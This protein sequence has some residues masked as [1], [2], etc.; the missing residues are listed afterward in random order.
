MRKKFRTYWRPVVCFLLGLFLGF[1]LWSGGA[2]DIVCGA[3]NATYR[4]EGLNLAMSDGQ[5]LFYPSPD[6]SGALWTYLDRVPVRGQLTDG[7]TGAAV[8]LVQVPGGRGA[9]SYIAAAV[10]DDGRVKGTNAILLG[11]RVAIL[12]VE[13]L[14]EIIWVHL[15]TRA[16]GQPAEFPPDVQVTRQFYLRDGVLVEIG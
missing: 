10:L 13:V 9:Y 8:T 1:L 4:V 12:G 11:D 14:D 6:T 5:S 16:E 15:L 2:P 3:I 7:V